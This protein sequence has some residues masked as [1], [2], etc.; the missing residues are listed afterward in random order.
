MPRCFLMESLTPCILIRE[1]L[2][3]KGRLPETL[4]HDRHRASV[5]FKE[6]K[7]EVPA[8]RRTVE[9]KPEDPIRL[10]AQAVGLPTLADLDLPAKGQAPGLW[11]CACEHLFGRDEPRD[12]GRRTRKPP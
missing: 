9:A 2:P 1:N 4:P 11:R 8:L 10:D 7:G 6:E 3:E 12:A 5:G